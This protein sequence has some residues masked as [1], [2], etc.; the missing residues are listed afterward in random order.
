MLLVVKTGGDLLKDG[1]PESLMEDLAEVSHSNQVIVVHGGGDIVTDISTKLGHP[2]RFV[3]S[4]KGFRSRYTDREEAQ[5]FTMVMA[6][7]INKELVLGLQKAGVNAL[8]L[9]GLDAGLLKA[10]RKKQLVVIDDRGRKRLIDGGYTG[11]IQR[12]NETILN[13]LLGMGVTPV[14]SPVAMSEEHYY[15]NVDG[16]RTASSVA[17]AVNADKLILLTDVDGIHLDGS[18]VPHLSVK[19]VEETLKRI[20]PGMVTKV[21]AAVEAVRGGVKEAV[22]ASGFKA[23]PV[24]SAINHQESTVIDDE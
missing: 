4:P 12:V 15:L 20:G 9:S 24:T 5:I 13:A 1:C 14:I 19:R 11:K 3:T 10:V 2:P 21:Y 16:D 6:G 23:A 18:N 17:Q 7:K 22:I 8:G